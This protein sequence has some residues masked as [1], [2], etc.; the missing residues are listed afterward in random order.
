MWINLTGK[1]FFVSLI[2]DFFFSPVNLSLK[3]IKGKLL[4][5]SPEE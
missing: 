3:A 1:T 4:E 5:I 2:L